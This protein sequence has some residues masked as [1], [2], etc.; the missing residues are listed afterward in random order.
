MCVQKNKSEQ[1]ESQ[2]S[3]ELPVDVFIQGQNLDQGSKSSIISV[4]KKTFLRKKQEV[5]IEISEKTEN[6][7][8]A[9]NDGYHA[10]DIDEQEYITEDELESAV[11]S[12]Y[13]K[14]DTVANQRFVNNLGN[15]NLESSGEILV[16]SRD[17][18]GSKVRFYKCD[19]IHKVIVEMTDPW[20]DTRYLAS[21]FDSHQSAQSF[22]RDIR[23]LKNKDSHLYREGN[24]LRVEGE[25]IQKE[26]GVNDHVVFDGVAKSFLMGT[27]VGLLLGILG[28]G[29]L[30]TILCVVTVLLLDYVRAFWKS[31]Y[32]SQTE[33]FYLHGFDES[34]SEHGFKISDIEEM[35]VEEK[36]NDKIRIEID[37]NIHL[38]SE[39]TDASWT[40][41]TI[42]NSNLPSGDSSEFINQ[43]GIERISEDSFRARVEKRVEDP[44][45]YCIESDCGEWY[46][47]PE[48]DY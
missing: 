44:G 14:T 46:L 29:L 8:Y 42:K 47:Y 40:L 9:A 10:Q 20:K 17:L 4:E 18:D 35:E 28:L 30:L 33:Q 39:D 13:Y 1:V 6:R 11:Q 23:G 27:F 38:E 36:L 3:S 19:V 22:A 21:E 7:I 48:V 37:D 12:E 43:L 31:R 16:F 32:A 26:K 24:Y 2:N 15:K 34:M 25:P 41:D 45:V 5:D